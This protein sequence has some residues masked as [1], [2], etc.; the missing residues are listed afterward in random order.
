MKAK[1]KSVG[2]SVPDVGG[3]WGRQALV[4]EIIGKAALQY[5]TQLPYY[6][7]LY[8]ECRLPGWCVCVRPNAVYSILLYMLRAAREVIPA[9]GSIAIMAAPDTSS[10]SRR[11]RLSVAGSGRGVAPGSEYVI[12]L[13]RDCESSNLRCDVAEDGF[14][15]ISVVLPLAG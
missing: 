5:S 6:L 13:R 7:L 9:S 10:M 4:G 15:R 12:R 3:E 1:N 2:A 14:T 11:I 8:W